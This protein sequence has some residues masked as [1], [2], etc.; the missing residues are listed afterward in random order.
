MI[1][2]IRAFIAGAYSLVKDGLVLVWYCIGF[3]RKKEW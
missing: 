2:R 3:G 1:T